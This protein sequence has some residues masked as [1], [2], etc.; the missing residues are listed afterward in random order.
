MPETR[1]AGSTFGV[2]RGDCW[3]KGSRSRGRISSLTVSAEDRQIIRQLVMAVYMRRC[4]E[5]LWGPRGEGDES[6]EVHPCV[7]S[8]ASM[9]R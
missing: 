3:G 6:C 1:E 7:T 5:T 2:V 4:G 8:G 9:L